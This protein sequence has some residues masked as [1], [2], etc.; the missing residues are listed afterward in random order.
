LNPTLLIAAVA[1]PLAAIVGA[2][3]GYLATRKRDVSQV[4][5]DRGRLELDD[6]R[7]ALE[8]WAEYATTVREDVKVSRD[9]IKGLELM[10]ADLN[11][12]LD[13]C[14]R[15]RLPPRARRN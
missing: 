15:R 9:R 14:L 11:L 13:D 6:A 2:Y 5:L 3:L 10:I 1:T 8:A 7:A 4:T 12:K